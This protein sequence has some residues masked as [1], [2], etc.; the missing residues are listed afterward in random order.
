MQTEEK[1]LSGE[2]AFVKAV[3][4]GLRDVDEGRVVPV[5]EAKKRLELM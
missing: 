5:E 3:Q 1:T 4:K 2:L